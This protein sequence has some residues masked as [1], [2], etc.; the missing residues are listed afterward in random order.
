MNAP[1]IIPVEGR[2]CG[3][4]AMCCKLGAIAEVNKPDGEWC[5]HCSSHM[6]CDIYESR[7]EVCR[8]YYCYFMLS[9]L[10]EE[11]RPTTAKFMLSMMQDGA[12]YVSVDRAR[13]DAWR[14][15]PYFTNI[16]HWSKTRRVVVLVGVKAI[17]VYP[18]RIETLGN[19]ENGYALTTREEQT[20]DGVVKRT[21]RVHINELPKN[22]VLHTAA[23]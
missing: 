2:A 19:L 7:P 22:A 10:G 6:A 13:P 23:Y 9:M 3:D 15:E 21:V 12:L 1:V 18:D 8:V 17:A 11:W 20:P 16:K 14:K 4:C 5:T